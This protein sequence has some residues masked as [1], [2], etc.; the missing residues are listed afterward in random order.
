[1]HKFGLDI[2]SG[3]VGLLRIATLFKTAELEEKKKEREGE[4]GE[5]SALLPARCTPEFNLQRWTINARRRQGALMLVARGK[6]NVQKTT[7]EGHRKEH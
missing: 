5:S 1:M 2:D 4:L 7:Y 6:P 3:R